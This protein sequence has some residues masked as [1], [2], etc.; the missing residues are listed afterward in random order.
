MDC[1]MHFIKEIYWWAL[2]H[3]ITNKPESSKSSVGQY[4]VKMGIFFD[5]AP[6]IPVA[7]ILQ[8]YYPI[9]LLFK[10]PKVAEI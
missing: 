9:Y 4:L 1:S 2:F 5:G 10:G 3:P 6:I 8:F 7:Y